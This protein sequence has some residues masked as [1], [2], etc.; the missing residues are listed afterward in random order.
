MNPFAKILNT[1]KCVCG[2]L[3][4]I[5]IAIFLYGL[6]VNGFDV[7][8][9]IGIGTVIGSVFIFIMGIFLVTTEEMLRN[10]R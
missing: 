10:K 7:L 4:T 2:V 8:A 3:L 1:T 5:G 9:G 6:F